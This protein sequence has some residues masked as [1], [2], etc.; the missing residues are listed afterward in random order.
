MKKMVLILILVIP[1]LIALVITLIAGFVGREASFHPVQSVFIATGHNSAEERMFRD[2]GTN[3]GHVSDDFPTYE[4]GVVYVGERINLGQYIAVMPRRARFRDLDRR[5]L[6]RGAPIP[7]GEEPAILCDNGFLTGLT[8]SV[9]GVTIII[10]T[11]DGD[12]ALAFDIL[13]VR[14]RGGA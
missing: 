14:V 11:S 2:L 6:E 4:I 7:E 5:Y 8:P 1:V 12:Q 3:V 13:A 9:R 10:L